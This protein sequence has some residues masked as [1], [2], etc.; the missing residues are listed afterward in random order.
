MPVPCIGCRHLVVS[1]NERRP[2]YRAP[3]DR[4]R[5]LRRECSASLRMPVCLQSGRRINFRKRKSKSRRSC[6]VSAGARGAEAMPAITAR[7]G[8]AQGFRSKNTRN[9]CQSPCRPSAALP[10]GARMS[11][12]CRLSIGAPPAVF[13]ENS[14][15]SPKRLREQLWRNR[16]ARA[17]A[18][19]QRVRAPF[20]P[21]TRVARASRRVAGGVAGS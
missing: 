15:V 9:V 5:L 18:A 8:P 1:R 16:A 7:K 21:A 12:P 2:R 13:D 3:G 6:G 4:P 17:V 19:A 10:A 20:A 14:P 11:V